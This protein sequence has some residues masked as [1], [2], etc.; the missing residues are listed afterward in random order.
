MMDIE[1]YNWTKE[2]NK[3]LEI[4]NQLIKKKRNDE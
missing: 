2:E 4:Y 1:K 3:L